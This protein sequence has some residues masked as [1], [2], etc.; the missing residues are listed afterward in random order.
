MGGAV[1]PQTLRISAP[2]PTLALPHLAE[3][4]VGGEVVADGILPAFVVVLEEGKR[5]LDLTDDLKPPTGPVGPAPRREPGPGAVAA[6]PLPHSR[7]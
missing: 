7:A 5:G 2:A 6:P 3:A 1:R 4:S